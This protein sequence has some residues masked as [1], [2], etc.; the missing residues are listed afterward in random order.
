MFN[1][2]DTLDTRGTA[3]RF[4]DGGSRIRIVTSAEDVVHYDERARPNSVYV[5]AALATEPTDLA[6]RVND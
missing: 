3:V 5:D 1:L 6:D 2:H 4:L